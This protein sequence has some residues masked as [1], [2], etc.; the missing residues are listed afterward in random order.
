MRI[1]H[2]EGLRHSVD[3]HCIDSKSV[4]LD[5]ASVSGVDSHHVGCSGLIPQARWEQSGLQILYH[6]ALGAP[7]DDRAD[8]LE[9]KVAGDLDEGMRQSQVAAD[10]DNKGILANGIEELPLE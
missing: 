9:F 3:Y 2:E 1:V 6:I 10:V 4:D 8:C 5:V 7:L